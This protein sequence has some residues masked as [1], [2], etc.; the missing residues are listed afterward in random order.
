MSAAS[1]VQFA[2]FIVVIVVTGVPLGRYM[3]RVYGDD[4]KAPPG[5]RIFGPIERAIYR[6]CRINPKSEQRWTT[7]AYALIGFSIFSF[8]LLYL[9]Q[10]VAGVV[11]AE[12]DRGRQRHPSPVVQHGDQLRH[13]HE[14]AVLRR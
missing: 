10:R 9:L 4:E 1:W 14:L 7:Y 5:D 11:A 13:E 8:V 3:A 12:P 6:I 2:A